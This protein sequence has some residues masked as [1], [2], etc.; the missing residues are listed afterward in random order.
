MITTARSLWVWTATSLVILMWLPLLAVVRLFDRDPVRYRTGLWFRKLG[1][2]LT[3]INPLWQL[4]ISGVAIDNPRHPYV[5]VSNHQSFADIP[6]VSHVPWEMKWIAKAELFRFPVVGW[7]MRMAG[8]IPVERNDRRKAAQAILLA[9]KYL[10]QRC[11]VMIFPEGTRSPD[12]NVQ[13]FSDGAFHLAIRAG[14]PVLPL[15]VEGSYRCLPKHSWRFGEPS[16]I[17]LHVM[18]P[19][20]TS[21]MTLGDVGSLRD[22][23]RL[24]IVEQVA[25]MRGVLPEDVDGP[26]RPE[27]SSYQKIENGR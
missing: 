6:L 24:G 1:V 20:E 17:Q 2:V 13:R 26:P 16:R 15:A 14:V 22:R 12:G 8:D 23:V 7:M 10:D 18:A 27:S 4:S 3:K 11:S 5:V 25:A 21:G 19:V 9:H